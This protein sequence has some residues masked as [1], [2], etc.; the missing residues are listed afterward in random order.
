M[1]DK[2]FLGDTAI[3]E[4]DIFTD[5]NGLVPDYPISVTW[6]LADPNGNR[7]ILSTLPTSTIT[8]DN[9]NTTQTINGAGG[10]TS[11]ITITGD[12]T[13][14]K[15]NYKLEYDNI[16][17]KTGYDCCKYLVNKCLETGE[18]LPTVYVHSAN[19]IGAANMMG[20]INNYLMNCR[21]PQTCIRV[22][23]EHTIDE[24]HQLSPEATVTTCL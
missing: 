21:L 14:V 16:L 24:T 9:N 1:A 18:T 7:L 19:P 11:N 4:A 23:I 20:Y 12:Y 2:V 3:V 6:E 5:Q 10:K 17:E 22:K 15:H 13:N 8:G